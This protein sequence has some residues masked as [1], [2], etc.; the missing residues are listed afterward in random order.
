MCIRPVV[1]V[2][3]YLDIRRAE[4]E[5]RTLVAKQ[6]DGIIRARLWFGYSWAY[7]THFFLWGGAEIIL[8]EMGNFLWL[9]NC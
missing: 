5:P 4:F 2:V 3:L 1:V 9:Y 7:L 8:M 6:T